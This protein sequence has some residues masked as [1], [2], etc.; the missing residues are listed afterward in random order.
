MKREEFLARLEQGLAGLGEEERAEALKFYNEYLDEVGPGQEEQEIARLGDPRRVA[1]IIRANLG[2]GP[3]PH[4]DGAEAAPEMAEAPCAVRQ[5]PG[6]SPEDM[7]GQQG[8]QRPQ[9]DMGSLNAGGEEDAAAPELTLEGPA[10]AGPQNGEETGPAPAPGSV[11]D[12]AQQVCQAAWKSAQ[13]HVQAAA[14]SA[15]EAARASVKAGAQGAS[16]ACGDARSR[17]GDNGVLWL[18]II[19]LTFPVWIGVLGGIFGALFGIIGGLC[20]LVLGG[21]GVILGGVLALV[22]SL[23]LFAS[24][25]MNAVVN[26]GLSL[27][28]MA[29][30]GV[31]AGIGVAVVQRL[32]PWV[33]GL[34]GRLAK[35][36]SGK[37]GGRR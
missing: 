7:P 10:Q 3:A 12:V 26:M 17:M 15:Y 9:P 35:W 18:I 8:P 6:L 22:R 33:F 23:L 36:V 21:F 1:N 13:P 37:V 4:G 2:L 32:A 29:L 31:L 14:S 11:Q 30:G 20:G 16:A 24:A 27:V 25:P 19:I 28:C 5:E 34:I